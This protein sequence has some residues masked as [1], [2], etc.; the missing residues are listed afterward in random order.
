MTAVPPEVKALAD[1]WVLDPDNPSG[2]ATKLQW[3]NTW[4]GLYLGCDDDLAYPPDYADVMAAWVDHWAG[5]ALVTTHGRILRPRARSFLHADFAAKTL[6]D[7][8]RGRWVN[9][10]GGCGL[11]F[12]T[13]LGV[14]T[15]VPGRNTEEPGL[16]VW[17]QR[18]G[19]PIWLVAHPADWLT[20][21]LDRTAPLE[22]DPDQP[23]YT[24]WAEESAGKFAN[25]DALLAAQGR[26]RGWTVHRPAVLA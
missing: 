6:D 16:A 5:Q 9:Y 19:V 22:P 13:R 7:V 23:G 1:A 3:A 21:L 25:R 24:I 4:D 18:V 2:S 15:H 12:D 26:T 8:A 17:A 11:A 10:P 20:Y 14:P